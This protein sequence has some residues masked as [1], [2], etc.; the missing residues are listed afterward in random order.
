MINYIVQVILFQLLFLVVYDLFLSKE[1]FF[2]KNRLYLISSVLISFVLP[3]LKFSSFKNTI[4]EEYSI[5]LPEIVLSPQN[6]IENTSLGKI[7]IEENHISYL[8][9]IFYIGASISLVLFLIKLFKLVKYITLYRSKTERIVTIPETNIAF[10][11]FNYIFLGENISLDKKKEIIEHELVHIKQKHSLDLL[12]FEVLRIVMWFN[13]LVYTYQ[14]RITLVH[15]YLSDSALIEKQQKDTYINHILTSFFD[16]ENV[17]FV[18]QFYKHSFIKK[19]IMMMTKE[20]SKRMN[21]WK[22]IL[23]LPL[24]LSMIIYSSCAQNGIESYTLS[25]DFT[26][27]YKGDGGNLTSVKLNSKSVFDSYFGPVYP[28]KK[29]I[30]IHNLT[31]AELQEYEKIIGRQVVRNPN[32]KKFDVQLFELENGRKLIAYFADDEKPKN[33]ILG[34]VESHLSDEQT[35]A[36]T[37]FVNSIPFSVIDKI[38][39]FPGCEDDDKY[40]FNK[41]VQLHFVQNFDSDLPKKLGLKPGKKRIIVLFKIDRTG[42]VTDIKVKAPAKELEEELIKIMEKLPQMIPG[43]HKGVKVNVKYTLPIRIDVK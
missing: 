8:E 10:S 26:T 30:T 34:K 33:I 25:K 9:I 39:T 40:C 6:V 42:K 23:I 32:F 38:P 27:I 16:V 18:N 15:E 11:F 19:R 4:S 5:V 17:S 22:Y 21:L 14:K 28:F 1:T 20:K 13:P 12:F 41:N 24:V 2:K 43:E 37:Y 3:F 31:V 35:G 7:L 36:K 29:Q